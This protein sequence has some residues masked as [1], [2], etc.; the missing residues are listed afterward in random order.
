MTSTTLDS[1]PE[2]QGPAL[3]CE[4]PPAASRASLLTRLRQD[5]TVR[6]ERRAF[7]RA[8]RVAGPTEQGDLL[9]LVRRS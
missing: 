2:L 7:E 8:I 3:V 6:R 5:L 4:L 9:A 1:L